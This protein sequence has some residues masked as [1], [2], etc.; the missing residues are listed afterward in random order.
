MPKRSTTERFS[1]FTDDAPHEYPRPEQ[2]SVPPKVDIPAPVSVVTRPLA[3]TRVLSDKVP[4]SSR[5]SPAAQETLARL[6]ECTGR[7]VTHLLDE[8]LSDLFAKYMNELA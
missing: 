1:S 3:R 5:V 2:T 6:V 7:P 8:A 4:F